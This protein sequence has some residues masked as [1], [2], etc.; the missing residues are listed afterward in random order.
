DA[1]ASPNVNLVDQFSDASGV[2][3]VVR[4]P[5]FL[6]APASKNGGTA[7]LNGP[8]LKCYNITPAGPPAH[9]QVTLCDQ[10]FPCP[11]GDLTL[12]DAVKVQTSQ[13][14]CTLTCKG[15]AFDPATGACG[16]PPE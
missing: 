6:C 14:L 3:H 2:D 8:H 7:D 9:D 4:E 1:P 11:G 16:P 12:G 15:A 10:F 5:Q 13:L